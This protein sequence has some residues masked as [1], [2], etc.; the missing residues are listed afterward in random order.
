MPNDPNEIK[1]EV[2]HHISEKPSAPKNGLKVI[3][4]HIALF[5]LTFASVSYAGILWVG[6]TALYQDFWPLFKDGAV[7]ATLLLGFLTTHEFGHYFAAKWHKIKVTLPYFIPVPFLGIG[8]LGAVIRI[9]EPIH[10]T[11][12]LFDIGIAGPL[13]GFVVAIGII[14][15]GLINLPDA[16]YIQQFD[17]HDAVK[18]YV[19]EQ[20]VYPESPPDKNSDTLYLGNTLLFDWLS[21]LNKQSPPLWELYH[22]PWLFAGWLGL[23]FTALNLTPVGQ[24]DGGHILYGLIGPKGHSIVSRSIVFLLSILAGIGAMGSLML[25]D[26]LSLGGSFIGFYWLGWA[27]GLVVVFRKLFKNDQRLVILGTSLSMLLSALLLWSGYIKSPES[28]LMWLIWLIF[29]SFFAGIDHPPV[30]KRESLSK[31]RQIL[32]WISMI[33]YL[34]CFTLNPIYTI[35]N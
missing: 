33:I 17:G 28:Y 29:L 26:P 16:S 2:D 32:G 3:L 25:Q 12:K 27:F 30:I 34:L 13:A 6:K 22:Y 5:L 10:S 1:I 24:L 31:N 15:Y 18:A 11:K 23:F 19:A 9:K 8:T 7:F 4:I 20:G 21:T 35:A 14:A